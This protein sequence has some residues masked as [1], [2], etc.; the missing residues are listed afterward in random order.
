MYDFWSASFCNFDWC[1]IQG[2]LLADKSD[3]RKVKHFLCTRKGYLR[4]L[5]SNPYF[6]VS[7]KLGFKKS[8]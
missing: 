7:L 1:S 8:C 4:I 3:C 5:P 2:K 6:S